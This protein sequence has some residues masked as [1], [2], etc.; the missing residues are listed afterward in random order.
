MLLP[1]Q[2]VCMKAYIFFSVHEELFHR[3]SEHLRDNGI[4]AFSGFVWGQP[5]IESISGRGIDYRDVVVFS[6]D[7]LPKV[8]DG[9]PPDLA[10]LA[11]REQEL[12]ISIQRLLVV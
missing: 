11:R 3:L 4:T 8:D 12:G 9:Q 2:A 7:L 1:A 5:Q 6:R 10:W